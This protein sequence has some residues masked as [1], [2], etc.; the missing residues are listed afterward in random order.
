[1]DGLGWP[2]PMI[3]PGPAKIDTHCESGVIKSGNGDSTSMLPIS[4]TLVSVPFGQSLEGGGI[5]GEEG[6]RSPSW[7]SAFPGSAKKR[8]RCRAVVH[9]RGGGLRGPGYASARRSTVTVG[10]GTKSISR[11]WPRVSLAICHLSLKRWRAS[12]SVVGR[13]AYSPPFGFHAW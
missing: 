3:R 10:E 12:W 4:L 9:S 7:G 2:F 1:M 11:V 13:P 5:H 6:F 8:R